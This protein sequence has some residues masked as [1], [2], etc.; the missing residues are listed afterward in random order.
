MKG[1]KDY[2]THQLIIEANEKLSG[3]FTN[4]VD[5]VFKLID[6]SEV[7]KG[8]TL[9]INK[10]WLANYFGEEVDSAKSVEIVN[11]LFSEIAMNKKSKTVPC[12]YAEGKKCIKISRDFN[13]DIIA[14]IDTVNNKLENSLYMIEFK[15]SDINTIE[16][17]IKK[18]NTKKSLTL[19]CTGEGSSDRKPTTSQQ[20]SGTCV[21][22]NRFVDD[23][24]SSK[25]KDFSNYIKN[26]FEDNKWKV[27]LNEI[28]DKE[29]SYKFDNSWLQHFKYQITAIAD[30]IK[31]LGQEPKEY[32]AAR[33][34]DKKDEIC[35]LY[36]DFVKRYSRVNNN[37]KN[38]FDPSDL[39]IY[40]YNDT[41]NINNL[42]RNCTNK[43]NNS[44][45]AAAKQEYLNELF[46]T[47][48]CMGISSKKLTSDSVDYVL[49][50]DSVDSSLIEEFEIQEEYV[51]GKNG[52]ANNIEIICQCSFKGNPEITKPS[53]KYSDTSEIGRAEPVYASDLKKI[54]VVVRTFGK[55]QVAM[56]CFLNNVN[57]NSKHPPIGKCPVGI[58]KNKFKE[59]FDNNLDL[60]E[61]L[62]INDWMLLFETK[63]LG[64]TD[65]NKTEYMQ[66][67]I[68]GAMK[69]GPLCFPFILIY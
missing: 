51:G 52:S 36:T 64:A 48:L 42:I 24:N 66:D 29:I 5:D 14:A 1:I 33:F 69:Y 9:N 30:A 37:N 12:K 11:A 15:F 62:K 8:K 4:D 7:K 57:V 46:N 65:K 59:Y 31:Q 68:K 26:F 61:K 38:V 2:I 32:K 25:N 47:R 50:N 49:F 39:I 63:F 16:V 55:E 58:W 6:G 45:A 20:E 67:C 21:L 54:K 40:K 53:K 35:K 19:F 27:N 23:F 13:K 60:S 22:W 18:I 28:F 44:S 3:A 56:D 10:E 41:E 34:G 43:L 17:S